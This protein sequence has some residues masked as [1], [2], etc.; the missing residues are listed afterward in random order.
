[1]KK[2]LLL[3]CVLL[4]GANSFAQ[5]SLNSLNVAHTEDFDGMG[6]TGTA[7]LP[8]WTAIKYAGSSTTVATGA[9]L[10]MAVTNGAATSGGI[11]NVGTTDATERAFGSLASG[12]IIPA[13]G[14]SF[15]NNTGSTVT[16]IDFA[17]VMEQWRSG[18]NATVNEVLPFEYSLDA[19]SLSTGTWI[20]LTAMNFNEI[21]IATTTAAAVDGNNAANRAVIS[22]TVYGLNW[23][24]GTTLWIRWTDADNT[25]SDGIY[26][27]DDFSITPKIATP[28]GSLTLLAPNGGEVLTAGETVTFSWNATDVEQVKFEVW[29]PD[30]W[31]TIV[32]GPIDATLGELDFPIPPN[33]WTWNGYKIRVV[34]YTTDLIND[35]SDA[36]FTINGHNKDLLYADFNTGLGVMTTV[37]NGGDQVWVTTSNTYAEMNGYSGSAQLNNDWLITPAIN[38]DNSHKE[39]LEF[40]TSNAFTG[41]VLKVKYSTN[42]TGDGD[43]DGANWTELT[44]TKGANNDAWTHSGYIDLN[45]ITG[46]IYLAFEYTSNPTDGAARWRVTDIHISGIEGWPLAVDEPVKKQQLFVANP[47]TDKMKVVSEKAISSITFYSI[48]G[49]MAKQVYNPANYEVAVA[50]LANGMYLVQ[51]KFQDGTSSTAKVVKK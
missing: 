32:P 21:L 43:V 26:A 24:N 36:A 15:I 46:T 33:A 48:S 19:T 45:A 12:S 6:A 4:I 2:I 7:Y 42:Y 31:I 11:Y 35:E 51:I 22:A 34:N 28:P 20:P 38:L 50:D 17:G 37:N 29:T 25:N 8:G 1:M 44:Y 39:I 14:A 5:I 47:V 27:I 49:K 30:G 3:L 9:T 40:S 16:A 41:P 18:S 23:V 13:F 10:T